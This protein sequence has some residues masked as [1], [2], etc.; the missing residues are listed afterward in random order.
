MT[1][2]FGVI[3]FILL[4][5]TGVAHGQ[6]SED[7]PIDTWRLCPAGGLLPRLDASLQ[8]PEDGRIIINADTIEA[9]SESESRLNG[10]VTVISD[11]DFMRADQALYRLDNQTMTLLGNVQYRSDLIEFNADSLVRDLTDSQSEVSNLDFYIPASHGYG[12]A[13][14]VTRDGPD[15]TYLKNTTY[16]TCGSDHRFWYFKASSLKLDHEKGMGLAKNMTLRILNVPVFYFPALSF[17]IDDRRKSGFL[18]PTF[19]NSS[20]HGFEFEIPYYWNI[21]PQADATFTPHS[22]QERGVQLRSE[23]RY[24]SSW[25]TNTLEYEFLDDDLYGDRRSRTVLQHSGSIGEHWSTSLNASDISDTEYLVDFGNDPNATS[26][27]H[28]PRTAMLTGQW[29]NWKLVSRVQSFQTIDPSIP[30]SSYPYELRPDL[31]LSGFYPDIG[32]AVEFE[33]ES[34]YTVFDRKNIIT[35]KRFDLWPRFSRSFGNSGWFVIPAVSGH[36]TSYQQD[37]PTLPDSEE[38]SINRSVPIFSLDNGLIFERSG[39]ADDSYTQ[40]FEPRLFYLNVPYREQDDIPIL[41]SKLPDFGFYQ[42]VA[43][44]RFTGIDRI[45][46][47]NQAS[48]ILTS[49]WL[50]RDSGEERFRVSLGQI[51]YFQDRRVTLP[52]QDPET[53]DRSGI[54]AGLNT[55]FGRYWSGSIDLEW[56]PEE[57]K[58]DK[59]LF[60]LRFNRQNRYVFNVSYRYRAATQPNASNIEQSDVSFSLPVGSR[61]SAVGRWNRSLEEKLDLDKY[62]GLEYESCCWAFRILSRR[63]LLPQEAGNPP[64]FDKSI[65]FEIVLKGLSGLGSGIG[66]RLEQNITGYKDPF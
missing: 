58:T 13:D 38:N 28:L 33:L 24:L 65:Y 34:R 48:L 40:T 44:N 2:R 29:D 64:E 45:G 17:P 53:T 43:E 39:A 27:T 36:F 51:R 3:V 50:R 20:R 47:A 6:K 60:R 26:L 54:L 8:Y 46:D 62:F 59:R 42:L 35:H 1:P 32:G 31:N 63:F 30:E 4:C 9:Q 14:T 11:K 52:N 57:E 37:D 61:W 41:D 21:A 12:S 22:M 10:N 49:R 5:A 7:E 15:I 56:N 16:S 55:R 66:Q 23:W 18:Y 25:S 19:G